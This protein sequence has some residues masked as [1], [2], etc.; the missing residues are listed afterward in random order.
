MSELFIK[1]VSEYVYKVEIHILNSF[2]FLVMSM[3]AQQVS[4]VIQFY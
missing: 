3:C 1:T 4:Q 2:I